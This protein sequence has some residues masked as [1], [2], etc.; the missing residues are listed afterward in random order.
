MTTT[1]RRPDPARASDATPVDARVDPDRAAARLE[2]GDRL[3]VRDHYS[4][5]AEILAALAERMPAPPVDAPNRRVQMAE[6]RAVARRLL[7]PVR[8]HQLALGG[9]RPI[10]FLAELYPDRA[11]LDLP[12]VDLQELRGAWVRYERGVAVPVLGHSLHPFYG[13]YL[14]TRMA[15][16]ELFAQWLRGGADGVRHAVDVGTGSGVMALMLARAGVPRITATDT[17]SNAI[18]S[19]RR[20]LKRV[21]YPAPIEARVGDL[22]EPVRAAADLVVFNPPWVPGT[23]DS[24]LDDALVYPPGLFARFFDQAHAGLAPGG[25]VVLVFSNILRLVRPDAPHPIEAE[26]ASGR[27]TLADQLQRRVKAEKGRRT[28]ERVEVWVLA[29]A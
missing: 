6:R 20:E 1:Y 23:P 21:A 13:T 12:F 4:T 11:D 2:A 22:L 5:G 26:L 7:A 15:H 19:V 14:P 17:S 3:R 9:G 8:G 16:L 10:G 18:E 28:K 29:R 25:R 27:F 24:P